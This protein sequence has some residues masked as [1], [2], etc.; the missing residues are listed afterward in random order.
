[1]GFC[2][3]FIFGNPSIYFSELSPAIFYAIG[4]VVRA[5]GYLFCRGWSLSD[6]EVAQ[7]NDDIAVS[8]RM[9]TIKLLVHLRNRKRF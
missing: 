5:Y 6:L 9:A 3:S 7:G 2:I 1:M 4:P 8:V